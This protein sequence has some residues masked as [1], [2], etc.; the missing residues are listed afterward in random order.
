MTS[1][2]SGISF[3]SFPSNVPL[4]TNVTT[5][6]P[7]LIGK[8]SKVKYNP[9]IDISKNYFI[10]R[11]ISELRQQVT[12]DGTPLPEGLSWGNLLESKKHEQA[13]KNIFAQH[14]LHLKE[15]AMKR[16][17]KDLDRKNFIKEIPKLNVDLPV[18]TRKKAVKQLLK[19]KAR[20][21]TLE[22]ELLQRTVPKKATRVQRSNSV[23]KRLFTPEDFKEYDKR[24]KSN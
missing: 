11:T 12:E 3:G 21:K 24:R 8:T 6:Q 13:N 9:N 1:N 16:A 20:N 15:Q 4:R 14:D 19:G 18:D 17:R 10:P 2:N 7:S 22:Q 5:G 23:N